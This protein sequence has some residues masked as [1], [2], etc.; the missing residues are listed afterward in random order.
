[1][2]IGTLTGIIVGAIPGLS[3]GMLIALSLPITFYFH[4]VDAVALLISMY[5]GSVSGGLITAALLRIPGA[6]A[7]VMTTLDAYPIA[8]GGEPRRALG[9]GIY[10][11]FVGGLVGWVALYLFTEPLSVLALRFGPFDYFALTMTAL[12]LIV[13]VS[14]GTMLKGLIAGVLGMLVAIPGIDPSSGRLRLTGGQHW[15]ESG[16][17]ILPVLVG[18][19]AISQVIVLATRHSDHATVIETGLGPVFLRTRQWARHWVNLLRS[20]ALGTIIGILP[21]IGASIGSVVSYAAAKAF[22]RTPERFG[23]GSEE[24]VIASEA[25]NNAT[26]GGALIPLIAIGIPGSVIDAILIGALAAHSLQPGPLLFTQNVDV[27]WAMIAAC[28]IANVLMFIAMIFLA[29]PIAK[30]ASVPRHY[31]VPIVSAFCVVG[32]FAAHNSMTDVWVMLGFG[33]LG[34]LLEKAE[35]PLAP[36]VIGLVIAPIAEA[37]LRSGLMASGGDAFEIFRH[38]IAVVC[39]IAAAVM[40]LWPL[41]ARLFSSRTFRARSNGEV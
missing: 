29:G 12:V 16:F 18:V 6:P 37:N 22:S 30:L 27:V 36:F 21:G 1:M 9:L 25:A 8:A 17:D 23:K 26:V 10:A 3:G 24:G 13:T 14:K 11:S 4:P 40:L 7:N 39:L 34:Y 41:I 31:L 35:Y 32:V 20:S 28:L 33:V 2:L 19:F 5:V 38:P 15:L